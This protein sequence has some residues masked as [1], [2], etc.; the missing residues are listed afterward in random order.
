MAVNITKIIPTTPHGFPHCL[1]QQRLSA[2]PPET[3]WS[4]WDECPRTHLWPWGKLLLLTSQCRD[5]QQELEP[6]FFGLAFF[7]FL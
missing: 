6:L 2:E 5:I 1:S 4:P 7:D 3:I